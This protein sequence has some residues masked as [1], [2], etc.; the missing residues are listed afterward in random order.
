MKKEDLFDAMG[1]INEEIIHDAQRKR[2]P[3]R[4]L[5]MRCAAAATCALAVLV[6]FLRS[7]FF[8]SRFDQGS[9]P[10]QAEGVFA[11]NATYPEP[12]AQHMS[13]GDF[14]ENDVH[15]EWWESYR[16]LTDRS[17]GYQ[18]ELQGYYSSIMGQLLAA[19]DQNTVCSPINIYIAF[20]M[21]AEVSEGTT[22]QQ[23]LDMLGCSDIDK[24]RGQ[25]NALWQ[26]NY[27]D[28]PALKSLLANSIWLDQSVS[29]NMETL[30]RLADQYYASSFSGIPG[31]EEM[32]EALRRWT[33][34][35]TGNLLSEYTKDMKIQPDTALEILSTIY[36]KATWVDVFR[37]NNTTQETFHGTL[38]DA[39]VDMMHRT[40]MMGV[41]RT[42]TFNA[43]SLNLTDS[44]TMTFYLPKEGVDVDALASDPHVLEAARYSEDDRWSYPLVHLSLPKFQ[45]KA[46]TDLIETIQSLGVTDALDPTRSDFT[47]LTTEKDELF[48]SK[49]E[50]AAL[51]EIDEEGVTGAAYT[52]LAVAEG[53]ALPDEEIDFIV[54]RPFMFIVTGRDGS[55]LFSGIVRNIE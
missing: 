4:V 37:E 48:V 2:A 8:K 15:W 47:P 33:D 35:N 1:E 38:G 49:A 20:A 6:V 7:P 10:M 30:K 25:V 18:K 27:V 28:T 40:D 46:K 16:K 45:V 22:R 39:S 53:A 24:L 29:Y 21:L 32:D 17:A 19:E 34:E 31:S 13:V 54:D 11:V 26:S 41:Y 3:R 5:W 42:D 12:V 44:G 36:Y 50:H 55:V 9:E 51:V 23:I 43:L 14:Y 52:E